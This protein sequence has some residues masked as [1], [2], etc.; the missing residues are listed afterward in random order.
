MVN[1]GDRWAVAL[2]YVRV[3][4]V[5]KSKSLSSRIHRE[6]ACVSVVPG[7]AGFRKGR[8]AGGQNP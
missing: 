8:K 4:G 2:M 6:R 1:P 7:H 3:Y 5:E